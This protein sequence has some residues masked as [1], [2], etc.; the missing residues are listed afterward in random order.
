M[1]IKIQN[2]SVIDDSR[3]L[4]NTVSGTFTGTGFVKLP[5]GTTAQR[6]VSPQ[7]GMIRY[8]TTLQKYEVYFNSQWSTIGSGVDF[9]IYDNRGTLRNTTTAITGDK[10]VV[11]NLGLFVFDSTSTEPDDDETCFA[12]TTGGRWLLESPHWDFIY[13]T[14]LPDEDLQNIL[15]KLVNNTITSVATV[16]QVSF[17]ASVYGART[18]DVALVNPSYTIDPRLTYFARVTAQDVVTIFINN[19]S[20]AVA[21]LATGLWEVAVIKDTI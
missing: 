4:I 3:N 5:A 17:T 1:A 21:S 8:N 20:A 14:S 10:Y 6:P 13:A 2:T 7:D 19:P 11:R 9:L 16:T 12:V 15:F 18:G